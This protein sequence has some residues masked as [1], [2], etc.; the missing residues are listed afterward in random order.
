MNASPHLSYILSSIWPQFQHPFSCNVVLL[1]VISRYISQ[2]E[3]FRLKCNITLVSILLKRKIRNII[4]VFMSLTQLHPRSFHWGIWLIGYVTRCFIF[5]VCMSTEDP[6]GG[7]IR[8]LYLIAQRH[9]S[10]VTTNARETQFFWCFWIFNIACNIL[11]IS[12]DLSYLSLCWVIWQKSGVAIKLTYFGCIYVAFPHKYMEML[13]IHFLKKDHSRNNMYG[14]SVML[15]LA[16]LTWLIEVNNT[17]N[18]HWH[19]RF[20]MHIKYVEFWNDI[21]SYICVLTN[22]H[23]NNFSFLISQRQETVTRQLCKA[24]INKFIVMYDL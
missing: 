5:K 2:A 18:L 15:P 9:Y 24:I 14:R 22:T 4:A 8:Q 11:W 16:T 7:A 3:S 12:Y 23:Q 1:C 6:H 10:D 13:K 17:F 21:C 19:T 20:K